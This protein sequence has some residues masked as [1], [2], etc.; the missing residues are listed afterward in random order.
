MDFFNT[1]TN[2]DFL[3]K[4]RISAVVSAILILGC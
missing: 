1:K 3:G 4:R 2:F